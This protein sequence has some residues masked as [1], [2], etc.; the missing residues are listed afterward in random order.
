M[1]RS[2]SRITLEITSIRV[3]RLQE[4]SPADALAEWFG[5]CENMM[6]WMAQQGRS[7]AD[8]I[9]DESAL[10]IR[11]FRELWNSINLKP[12]PIYETDENDNETKNIV[13]YI[14]YPWSLEDFG[15]KYLPAGME[16]TYHGKPLTVIPNPWLWVISFKKL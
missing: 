5:T 10:A 4:I 11:L 8:Y 14:S 13:G 2:A 12:K 9:G 1:P 15:E 3:E 6:E 16:R 7:T